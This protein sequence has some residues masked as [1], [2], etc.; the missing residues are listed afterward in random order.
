MRGDLNPARKKAA[1]NQHFAPLKL[2]GNASRELIERLAVPIPNE[3]THR[4]VLRARHHGIYIQTGTF[5]ELDD[6]YPG[7]VFNTTCLIGPD[8]ILAKYRKTH[9][10]IPWEVHASPHDFANYRDDPFPVVDTEIAARPSEN[11]T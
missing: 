5:L 9:P 4:Y 3:H 1:R 6:T 10:W 2:L 8:G 11:T 7:A